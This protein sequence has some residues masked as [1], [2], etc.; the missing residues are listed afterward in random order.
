[1]TPNQ[2]YFRMQNTFRRHCELQRRHVAKAD[3]RTG[4]NESYAFNWG[5]QAARD[6]V[7]RMNARWRRYDQAYRRMYQI[8]THQEHAD[9]AGRYLWCEHCKPFRKSRLIAA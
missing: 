4:G 2:L 9:E 6:A 5:N 8:V 7:F 1:M 3:P